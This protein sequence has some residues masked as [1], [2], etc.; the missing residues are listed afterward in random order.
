MIEGL[1]RRRDL[2]K[3]AAKEKGRDIAA[4]ALHAPSAPKLETV[5]EDSE[6]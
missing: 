3:L 2:E 1:D 5:C 6:F 4:P